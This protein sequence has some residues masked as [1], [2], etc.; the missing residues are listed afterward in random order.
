MGMEGAMSLSFSLVD[1]PLFA[2]GA[3]PSAWTVKA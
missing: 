2:V 3:S 1:G